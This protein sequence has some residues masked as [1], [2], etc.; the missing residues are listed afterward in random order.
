MDHA[1]REV[2]RR[3]PG[4]VKAKTPRKEGLIMHRYDYDF[5]VVFSLPENPV[6]RLFPNSGYLALIFT[7]VILAAAFR[8][9]IKLEKHLWLIFSL[10]FA[11]VGWLA[12]AFG[13]LSPERM[14]AAMWWTIVLVTV[15]H[16]IAAVAIAIGV[17]RTKSGWLKK[18]SVLHCGMGL[19]FM[20]FVSE[21]VSRVY[22]HYELE[23]HSVTNLYW[24]V[25][26]GIVAVYASW[27]FTRWILRVTEL[28]ADQ[29]A[30]TT[31]ATT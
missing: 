4:L 20:G 8:A 19:T 25:A 11:A 30:D 23:V 27:I 16:G 26:L 28:P 5:H 22:L 3:Y 14:F 31:S 21:L 24:W 18:Y 7:V 15:P 1:L 6:W 17:V 9:T 2:Q 29:S 12:L 13:L 10:F